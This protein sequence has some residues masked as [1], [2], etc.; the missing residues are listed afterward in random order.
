MDLDF[1]V[2]ISSWKYLSEVIMLLRMFGSVYD[3]LDVVNC[4]ACS[5]SSCTGFDIH[6][7]GAQY[8]FQGWIGI[9]LYL[10]AER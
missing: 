2:L 8:W 5:P 3:E 6:D 1:L 4:E 10:A 9:D 7:L